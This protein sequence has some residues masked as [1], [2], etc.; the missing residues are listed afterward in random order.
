MN[1][2]IIGLCIGMVSSSIISLFMSVFRTIKA[3]KRHIIAKRE[4]EVVEKDQQIQMEEILKTQK[5]IIRILDNIKNLD[6]ESAIEVLENT[7]KELEENINHIN[8]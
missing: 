3:Y 2:I 1:E 4:L 6:K 7:K 8:R 5:E